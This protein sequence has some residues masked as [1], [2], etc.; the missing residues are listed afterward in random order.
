MFAA[1]F[2]I[3][4]LNLP[5]GGHCLT[6]TCTHARTEFHYRPAA[7]EAA[8]RLSAQDAARLVLLRHEAIERCVCAVTL[9][10]PAQR[11]GYAAG[12]TRAPGDHDRTG[13]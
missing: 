10:I 7:V 3:D 1:R 5:E 4:P 6:V 12:R 13:W 9:I 2:S 8:L 11:D